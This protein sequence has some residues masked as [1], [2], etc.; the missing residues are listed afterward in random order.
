MYAA[1]E[2]SNSPIFPPTA[3]AKELLANSAFHENT[4]FAIRRAARNVFISP[5]TIPIHIPRN[6]RVPL[7]LNTFQ[8]RSYL[9]SYRVVFM[10]G[11]LCSGHEIPLGNSRTSSDIWNPLYA[12]V[13]G[14]SL[15][16]GDFKRLI[17][18]WFLP[19][20]VELTRSFPR[21][22]RNRDTEKRG[23]LAASIYTWQ[24][25]NCFRLWSCCSYYVYHSVWYTGCPVNFG[26][27]N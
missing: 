3:C 27:T 10:Q 14:V 1:T 8:P 9:F 15:Y 5:R 2:K 18:D 19:S 16:R 23:H 22:V 20:K 17:L 11:G 7:T 12:Y 26:T 4:L 21:V 25:S 24:C 13:V 6:F